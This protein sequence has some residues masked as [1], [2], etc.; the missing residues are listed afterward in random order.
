MIV[1]YIKNLNPIC[2]GAEVCLGYDAD[3]LFI[4]SL[5][6]CRLNQELQTS[7]SQDLTNC[8]RA[9]IIPAQ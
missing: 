5:Q 8:S 2:Y 4:S 9:F 1:D 3:F 7:R 6:L